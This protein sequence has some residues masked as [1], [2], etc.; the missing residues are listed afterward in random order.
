MNRTVEAAY[1][2]AEAD[3]QPGRGLDVGGT[4]HDVSVGVMGIL[5]VILGFLCGQQ[6]QPVRGQSQPCKVGNGRSVSDVKKKWVCWKSG[7]KSRMATM[8]REG[9]RLVEGCS[10]GNTEQ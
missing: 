8:K 9:R 5:K 3:F 10:G 6:P 4:V 7:V 2:V 1:R